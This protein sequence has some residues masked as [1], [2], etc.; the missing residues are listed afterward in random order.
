M[1]RKKNRGNNGK[2]RIYERVKNMDKRNVFL[3]YAAL[4]AAA[5][6]LCGSFSACG[7]VDETKDL[8]VPESVEEQNVSD[9]SSDDGGSEETAEVSSKADESATVS[10]TTT[11]TT[12]VTTTAVSKKTTTAKA[13]QSKKKTTTSKAATTTKAA[14]ATSATTTKKAVTAIKVTPASGTYYTNCAANLRSGNGT[15]YSVIATLALNTEITV[16]GKCENG[17]YAVKAGGYSG[18]MSGSVMSSKMTVV[19]TAAKKKPTVTTT[20]KTNNTPSTQKPSSN[21]SQEDQARAVAKKIADE[22]R[23]TCGNEQSEK[24]IFLAELLVNEY[25]QRCQKGEGSDP[26]I[27][28]AYGVFIGGKCDCYGTSLALGMVLEE[29]GYKWRQVCYDTDPTTSGANYWNEVYFNWKNDFGYFGESIQ[30]ET[31]I[32]PSIMYCHSKSDG[33]EFGDSWEDNILLAYSNQGGN[34]DYEKIVENFIK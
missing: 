14:A 13:T 16:T 17:W 6:T 1:N 7:S 15:G 4:L 2:R 18:Y 22:V 3:K 19:T 29:L 8:T 5:V 10:T 24:Q 11:T 31:Y 32:S 21:L 25:V 26:I 34:P 28:T 33:F 12:T 30:L 27:Y 23:N 9:S 20:A